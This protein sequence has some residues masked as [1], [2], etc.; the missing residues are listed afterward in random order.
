ML[1]FNNLDNSLHAL[2]KKYIQNY[3]PY[4]IF[5]TEIKKNDNPIMQNKVCIL[6][7]KNQY[8]LVL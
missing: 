5:L 7:P 2:D 4:C 1:F 3:A 6:F 8:Y